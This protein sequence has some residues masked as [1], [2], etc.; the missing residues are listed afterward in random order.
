MPKPQPSTLTQSAACARSA[1]YLRVAA[2]N[3][4]GTVYDSNDLSTIRGGSLTILEA[5]RRLLGHIE[6]KLARCAT[7]EVIYCAASEL[8]ARLML[9]ESVT[10]AVAEQAEPLVV[11]ERRK[12]EARQKYKKR[13]AALQTAPTA[14]GSASVD[15][16]AALAREVEDVVRAFLGRNNEGWPFSLF[17]FAVATHPADGATAQPDS[18]FNALEGMNAADQHTRL[19]VAIPDAPS[20]SPLPKPEDAF[21]AIT[22]VLPAVVTRGRQRERRSKSADARKQVGRE[23]KGNFY[24]NELARLLEGAREA[25]Q[26]KQPL[27]DVLDRLSTSGYSFASSFED[28]IDDPKPEGLPPNLRNKLAV[29]SLDGNNF[30]RLR[31]A[32]M[33]KDLSELKDF[34][35]TLEWKRG[36]LLTN[37]LDWMI[38]TPGMRRSGGDPDADDGDTGTTTRLRFETL[39]WGGDEMCFVLPAWYGWEFI[40]R[41]REGLDGW[42]IPGETKPLSH[43]IGLVF[44]HYKAP[45]R[46]L[47]QAAADLSAL[48]KD[49]GPDGKSRAAET[50]VQA[51]A[52]EGI[53]HA[54]LDIESLR[55]R[56]FPAAPSPAAFSVRAANWGDLTKMLVSVR[57]N[58]GISQ[59]HR[60]YREA[61]R[62]GLLDAAMTGD[63]ENHVTK[64]IEAFGRLYPKQKDESE[65]LLA[66]DLLGKS[67]H[68]IAPG[69]NPPPGKPDHPL[70]PLFHVTLLQDYIAPL[71]EESR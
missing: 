1:V 23:Q 32:R 41:L 36:L 14:G 51:M 70:I 66:S 62:K 30:G 67:P 52:L 48:A 10:Q 21:C 44:G 27:R 64:M 68:L 5:P 65:R 46:E 8:F 69:S 7:V 39:Q 33:T 37:L 35:G 20:A 22:G 56:L 4:D 63:A 19:T 16:V 43:S 3:F 40:D 55:S 6:E 15:P 2:V 59:I 45:I 71:A 58:I 60:Q 25:E 50:V 9:A 47:S 26:E 11:P 13:L 49:K 29:V 31:R 53:D 17:T 34:S 42:I 28:I 57:D 24:A 61:V 38:T 18:I 12:G 54:E